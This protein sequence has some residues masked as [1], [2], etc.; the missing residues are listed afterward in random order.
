MPLHDI[1]AVTFLDYKGHEPVLVR[2]GRR[3]TFF[4]PDEPA[5]YQLLGEFNGNPEIP[6]LDYLTHLKK[7]RAQ[8]ISVRG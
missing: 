6:L 2:E 4:V 8:M 3:V 7:I 1:Y 5:I